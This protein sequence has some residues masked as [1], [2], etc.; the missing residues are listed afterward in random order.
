M[1]ALPM[2]LHHAARSGF[3]PG[4]WRDRLASACWMTSPH[5]SSATARR[6]GGAPHAHAEAATHHHAGRL[7]GARRR[8]PTWKNRPG[9]YCGLSRSSRLPACSGCPRAV[10]ADLHRRPRVGGCADS[11]R[12]RPSSSDL[13]SPDDPPERE[14]RAPCARPRLSSIRRDFHACACPHAR[15][16]V[17]RHDAT[18]L[19][20]KLLR[21][22]RGAC[23]PARRPAPRLPPRAFAPVP[24]G[25][26]ANPRA[27]RRLS[28]ATW[29]LCRPAAGRAIAIGQADRPRAPAA[30]MSR[31]M[32][33]RDRPGDA[34]CR[35]AR[36]LCGS[37]RTA[38]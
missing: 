11:A 21:R 3:H 12:P 8:R 20:I 35:P 37:G 34:A 6:H 26:S 16:R 32:P 28:F 36:G 22:S 15:C 24:S 14:A 18:D 30:G 17:R 10:T 23:F 9:E 1:A 13:R 19:P 7:E 27:R 25:H 33:T 2:P 29:T 38:A 4:R 31:A 5:R